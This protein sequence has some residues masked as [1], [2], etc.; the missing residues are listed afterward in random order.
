MNRI[1]KATTLR[2]LFCISY[3]LCSKIWTLPYLCVNP[4]NIKWTIF[5]NWILSFLF[6]HIISSS[7]SI[8]HFIIIEKSSLFCLVSRDIK[9]STFSRLE[10]IV[11]W[12]T[13]WKFWPKW[14]PTFFRFSCWYRCYFFIYL[15]I[16]ISKD[17]K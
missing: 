2:V 14:L 6:V 8:N 1:R 9:N 5:N 7:C 10:W 3:K 11:H 16:E 17:H 4:N 12:S 15:H 13:V